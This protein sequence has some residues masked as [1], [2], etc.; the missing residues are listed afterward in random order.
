MYLVGIDIA[1]Y[2][3]QCFMATTHGE[4]INEFSFDNNSNGFKLLLKHLSALYQ[5]LE[6]KIGLEAT[7][8]YGNTLKQSLSTNGYT[9]LE[10]NPYLAKHF[11][12]STTIRKTKTDKV[13]ARLLSSMLASV[14]YK[15]LHTKYY[16]INELK[17]LTRAR[18]SLIESRSNALVQITNALDIIFP[19]FKSHFNNRLGLTALYILKK[20]KTPERISKLTKTHF[21]TISNKSMGKFT[22]PKFLKLK[23]L[24]SDTIGIKSN[25][26]VTVMLVHIDLF[27]SIN[28]NIEMLET[29]IKSIM[30][31]TNCK[32]ITIPG[33]SLMSAATIL[34]EVT[35]FNNFSNS[36]KLIAFSGF[37]IAIHQSGESMS[38]GRLVKRGSSLLRKTIWNL[39]IGSIRLI[40][41]ITE[42]YH[43]KRAEGKH[44]NII[45]SA[46]SRKLIRIIYHLESNNINY[47]KN[48]IR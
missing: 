33:I 14:D 1:K 15:T 46:I 20:Y 9:F 25:S 36:S 26:I 16:H 23:E 41:E 18:N 45:F 24:A 35:D 34:G 17:S 30:N 28:S 4:I 5:S 12:K 10:F 22:Y 21:E 47:D 37:D 48:K 6:I 27:Y 8:H 31:L 2:S 32:M 13:D 39:V 19:E 11:F 44:R 29:E 38:Y 3:H 40:P 7:G 42:Y 43:K